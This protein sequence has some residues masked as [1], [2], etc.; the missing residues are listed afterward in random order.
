MD[1]EASLNV[2]EPN[3]SGTLPQDFEKYWAEIEN[4]VDNIVS[5]VVYLK[6][7]N[8]RDGFRTYEVRI[9]TP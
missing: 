9:K 2:L 5:E 1:S 3:Y 8:V 7:G 6:V 4:D